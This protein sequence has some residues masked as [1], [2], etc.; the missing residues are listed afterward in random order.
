M[1]LV[2]FLSLPMWHTILIGVYETLYFL[3]LPFIE[4][5]KIDKVNPWPWK[6]DAQ[7][8]RD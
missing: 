8:W 6:V 7:K 2:S 1:M 5:Y 3:E 4:Q